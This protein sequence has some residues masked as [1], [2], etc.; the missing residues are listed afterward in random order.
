MDV[1][2]HAREGHALLQVTDDGP[3]IR[4]ADLPHVFD[5]FWRASDAPAG[6][7]GLGLAIAAWIAEQHDGS[8]TAGNAPGGGAWFE[9]RL[10]LA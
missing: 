8:I 1:A 2:A 3:G 7:S 10:P 4:A 5:R 6:G 9:V